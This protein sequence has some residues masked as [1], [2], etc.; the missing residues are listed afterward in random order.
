MAAVTLVRRRDL[1]D[2]IGTAL[3]A[4]ATLAWGHRR[5]A[6]VLGMP[7]TTV[8][9]WLRD[10]AAFA[11]K[12]RSHFTAL[13]ALLDPQLSVIEARASP[14]QDAFEAIAVAHRAAC[15]RL[16]ETPL[17]RFASAATAGRLINN[18]S[19]PFPELW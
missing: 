6:G 8:R 10:F 13:A 3:A 15:R 11:G 2:I 5:I 9:G 4:K 1:A 16:G 12:I 17:W 14:F 19:P 7:E 18:T